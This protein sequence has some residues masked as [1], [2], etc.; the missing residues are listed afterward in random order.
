MCT[1]GWT[2]THIALQRIERRVDSLSNSVET[3]KSLSLV[4]RNRTVSQKVLGTSVTQQSATAL[5]KVAWQPVQ[6]VSP[7]TPSGHSNYSPF[8]PVSANPAVT[9]GAWESP[10][11]S[12]SQ[13]RSASEVSRPSRIPAPNQRSRPKAPS[14][15]IHKEDAGYNTSTSRQATGSKC[16]QAPLDDNINGSAL[17]SRAVRIANEELQRKGLT[18]RVSGGRM[19]TNSMLHPRRRE[20]ESS[21][22]ISAAPPDGTC[23]E[24]LPRSPPMPLSAPS[25]RPQ[26]TA[27]SPPFAACSV[28]A[29]QEASTPP[30]RKMHREPVSLRSVMRKSRLQQSSDTSIDTDAALWLAHQGRIA[31]AFAL[32][33]RVL[34]S[35]TGEGTRRVL[36]LLE[37][38]DPRN[39][40]AVLPAIQSRMLV[41]VI[42]SEL[43]QERNA[44]ALLPWLE[45]ALWLQHEGTVIFDEQQWDRASKA[46][47]GLSAS[48][49][50]I[51]VTAA[52]LHAFFHPAAKRALS[53]S[54]KRDRPAWQ[55]THS[56]LD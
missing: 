14:N 42:L 49:D 16:R 30:A 13:G 11:V 4:A 6:G 21:S 32:T 5:A 41:Q 20:P 47:R 1:A 44:E 26:A 40:F 19:P 24:P 29:E 23:D 27:H 35:D 28:V 50:A 18:P 51:G 46:V 33:W 43:Q 37:E 3:L 12:N 15:R 31:D 53:S 45:R 36:R 48:D 7:Q 8:T 56:W 34:A 38:C 17:L 39:V 22:A 52:R 55:K 2:D 25:N 10:L 54:P 9:D